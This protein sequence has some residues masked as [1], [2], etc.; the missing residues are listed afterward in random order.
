MST[1]TI[2][3]ADARA[4]A[5]ETPRNWKAPIAFGVF[6]V[7]SFVVFGLLGREGTSRLTFASS[8]DFFT[9]TPI[10]VPSQVA[11]IIVGVVLIALASVS[12]WLTWQRR[13]AAPMW[14]LLVF[15]VFFVFGLLVWIGTGATVPVVWLLTGTLALATPLVFGAMAGVISERVGVVNIAIEGQLLAGAFTS[16]LVA[17]LTQNPFMGLLAA[18]VAGALVSIILAVFSIKYLVEQVVVGVVLNML[19]IGLTSFLYSSVL[20]KNPSVLNSPV[21]FTREP[22][23]FLS[24]IPVIGPLLFNNTAI[25]YLMFITVAVVYI[26]L[27]HTRWG[28][29][30]RAVGEHPKAADTVGIKVNATRFW[31]VLLGGAV[32]G[33]GGAFFTLGAVGAFGKEMTSGQGYIAL[34]ALIFGRWNPLWAALAALLFGFA[35]NIKTLVTQVGADI[36]TEFLSMIPYLVTILAVAG[37]VGQSKAPAA[38]GKPYLK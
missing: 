17:S 10:E 24:E 11:G 36:P 6:A 35:I 1:A 8:T 16:A 20:N 19:V 23:P 34:A 25:T 3:E 28:L 33:M 4:S 5:I 9:I 31:N 18:L 2:T 22:I 37:F 32:A 27:F 30:V 14:M 12:A 38:S 21:K 26:G 15:G 7:V 13:P 29:R